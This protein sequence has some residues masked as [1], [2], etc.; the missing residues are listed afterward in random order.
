MRKQYNLPYR[1]SAKMSFWPLT[2]SGQTRKS[3]S[4][5][6]PDVSP[7]QSWYS[8]YLSFKFLATYMPLW[9]KHG[10]FFL[11]HLLSWEGRLG[12][13]LISCRKTVWLGIFPSFQC[14]VKVVYNRDSLTK[15][16]HYPGAEGPSKELTPKLV[17]T[18]SASSTT[19]N[20][21]PPTW[22]ILTQRFF[23]SQ[24]AMRNGR[25]L[26]NNGLVVYSPIL[27]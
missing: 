21:T 2:V 13:S 20:G 19:V 10:V 1:E 8:A 18:W 14:E 23:G 24:S 26:Q 17:D 5:Q 16:H 11:A 3:K 6:N 7:K 12:S 4:I 27:Y 25:R 22:I 15:S 9:K